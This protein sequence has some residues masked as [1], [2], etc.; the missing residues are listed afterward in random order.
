MPVPIG[1][2]ASCFFTPICAGQ[3]K[4]KQALKKLVLRDRHFEDGA[5]TA[6]Q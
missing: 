1:N 6:A 2:V 3:T 4:N 5:A